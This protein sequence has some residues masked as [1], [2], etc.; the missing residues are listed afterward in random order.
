MWPRRRTRHRN[1]RAG[2]AAARE[3]AAAS[4]AKA[5]D[6]LSRAEAAAGRD[7]TLARSLRDI[8][9]ENHFSDIVAAA[10]R[11]EP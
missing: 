4:L 1:A 3:E 11:G 9:A 2:L 5:E 8:R 10:F 7:R 6:D